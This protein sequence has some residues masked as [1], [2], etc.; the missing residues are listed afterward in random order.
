MRHKTI[1]AAAILLLAFAAARAGGEASAA[2]D[3]D[4][5]SPLPNGPEPVAPDP[6]RWP[7]KPEKGKARP[8]GGARP[9]GAERVA[10]GGVVQTPAEIDGGVPTPDGGAP[11]VE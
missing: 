6:R 8:D 1:F 11:P 10:D 4:T 7:E 5:I 9:P 3:T 2:P